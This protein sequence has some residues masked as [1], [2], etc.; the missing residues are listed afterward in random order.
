MLYLA[1]SK[2]EFGSSMNLSSLVVLS[3]PKNNLYSIKFCNAIRS[4]NLYMKI[5]AIT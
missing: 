1:A 5:E 4:C 3:P 2:K